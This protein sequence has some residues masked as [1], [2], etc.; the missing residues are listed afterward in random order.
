MTTRT[1]LLRL[2]PLLPLLRGGRRPGVPAGP[3]RRGRIGA[4]FVALAGLALLAT[5]CSATARAGIDPVRAQPSAA[6]RC[7]E[8]A[9]E[10]VLTDVSSDAA[11]NEEWARYVST[12]AGWTDGDSVFAYAVPGLGVLW[13]FA[14]A[15]VSGLLANGTR[16][17]GVYHSLFVVSD[18][19]RF[20]VMLGGTAARPTDLLGPRNGP[21]FYLSLA[22]IVEGPIFQELFTEERRVGANSLDF[23]PERTLVATFA[24]PSLRLISSAPVAGSVA[25]DWGAYIAR[26]GGFTYIYGANDV[27]VRKNAYV[28][29]TPSSD[30]YGAW[31]YWDGSGWSPSPAAAAPLLGDVDQEYS[32]T[33]YKGLYL[34]VTSDASRAFWNVADIYFGCSPVGP[35]LHRQQFVLSYLVGPVGAK[36]WGDVGVYVYDAVV[37]PALGGGNALVLSYDQNSLNFLS[38]LTYPAIY[39]PHYLEL[40]VSVSPG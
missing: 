28:A 30:L 20:K 10:A 2:L 16:E 25:I 3:G 5:C 37:Q 27:G 13:T 24:L 6:A 21:I 22:G 34:L 40:S 15:Y 26:F 9:R 19:G 23:V 11:L 14:D 1:P 18:G 39:R 32:V 31:T 36:V 17:R 8:V 7:A 12:D 29:R 38:T 35:F 33:H 4:A